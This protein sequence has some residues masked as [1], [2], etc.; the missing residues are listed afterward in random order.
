M[1]TTEY[2][3]ATNINSTQPTII[4]DFFQVFKVSVNE[5]SHKLN[6]RLINRSTQQGEQVL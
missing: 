3:V 6:I 2:G 5:Q 1:H 4:D